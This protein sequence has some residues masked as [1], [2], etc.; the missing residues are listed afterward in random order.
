MVKKTGKNFQKNFTFQITAL[1]EFLEPQNSAVN[2]G[3]AM[4][5]QQS[6]RVLG[7]LRRI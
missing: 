7:R 6:R 2:I 1:K 3:T 4:R 5:T